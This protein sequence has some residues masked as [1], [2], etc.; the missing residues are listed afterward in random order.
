VSTQTPFH[1]NDA[2]FH[3]ELLTGHRWATRV[4]DRLRQQIPEHCGYDVTVTPMEWRDGLHDL[5]RFRSEKDIV[6]GRRGEAECV[7]EVKSRGLHFTDDPSSYPERFDTAIVDTV[8]GWDS[9]VHRDQVIAVVL[10]SQATAGMLVVPV[11]TSRRSWVTE[12][13]WDDT[14]KHW[15]WNYEVPRDRL[16]RMADLVTY[17]A[18]G[19]W[20]AL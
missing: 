6:V 8:D 7:V 18:S 20:E 12:R 14:R 13:R 2:L 5:Q 19:N 1:R 11:R 16:A 15:A 9:K 10:V 3:R 17:I 4:G